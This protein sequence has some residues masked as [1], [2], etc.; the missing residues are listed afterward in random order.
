MFSPSKQGARLLAVK[1]EV[2]WRN[3][4]ARLVSSSEAEE[5]DIYHLSGKPFFDVI[6]AKSHVMP[7]YTLSLP[8]N[9]LLALPR[10]TVPVALRHGGKN[11][12]LSY[13]GDSSRPRFDSK[14]K[15]FVTE[16]HLKF[17]DACVFELIEPSSTNLLFKVHILRG[18][19][20]PDLLAVVDSRGKTPDTPIVLD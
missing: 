1:K 5:D 17:G 7:P 9:M 19:L 4:H 2:Q 3:P 12:K 18:D 10:A 13:I 20:P 14:W 15:T 8:T 11:W 16:N 6:L